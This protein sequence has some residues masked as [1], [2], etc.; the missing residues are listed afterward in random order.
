[1]ALS[2]PYAD[3]LGEVLTPSTALTSAA[4]TPVLET[5]FDIPVALP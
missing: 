5:K 2:P 1:M 4:T 3:P